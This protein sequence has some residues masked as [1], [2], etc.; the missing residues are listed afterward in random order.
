MATKTTTYNGTE[1]HKWARGAMKAARAVFGI[2]TITRVRVKGPW[3]LNGFPVQLDSEDCT[4]SQRGVYVEAPGGLTSQFLSPGVESELLI[5]FEFE[6]D[7]ETL[8]TA[9]DLEKKPAPLMNI[10][11][12]EEG[13]DDDTPS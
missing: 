12:D 13:G 9:G 1:C 10:E 7:D 2:D 4:L 3:I 11:L 5:T 6:A 8:P